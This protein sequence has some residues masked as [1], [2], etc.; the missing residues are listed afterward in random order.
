MHV[1]LNQASNVLYRFVH[2]SRLRVATQLLVGQLQK[3]LGNKDDCGYCKDTP[4]PTAVET[5]RL[6]KILPHSQAT[7]AT[8][9]DILLSSPV[10]L[11][12]SL[13]D[14]QVLRVVLFSSKVCVLAARGRTC[15]RTRCRNNAR[16]TRAP[17]QERLSR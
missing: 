4:T 6:L 7:H 12:L 1:Q 16:T 17:L 8:D 2:E 3:I 14:V 13:R 15:P 9:A 10:F 5:T 11:V